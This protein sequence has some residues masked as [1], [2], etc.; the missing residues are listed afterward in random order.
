[1][2]QTLVI[3]KMTSSRLQKYRASIISD[4]IFWIAAC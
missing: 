4:V 2:T 3:E 1:M